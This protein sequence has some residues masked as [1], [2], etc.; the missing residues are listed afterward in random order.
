MDS[1]RTDNMPARNSVESY[2]RRIRQQAGDTDALDSIA[3][4][5]REAF[6][7][8]MRLEIQLIFARAQIRELQAELEEVR[9][10]TR[11]SHDVL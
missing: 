3:D 7:R 11:R 1:L 6:L 8:N 10:L 2:F 5:A 4:I 9:S